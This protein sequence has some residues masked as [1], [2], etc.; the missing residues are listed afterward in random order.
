VYKGKDKGA[1]CDTNVPQEQ[2]F[3]VVGSDVVYCFRVTNIGD[4]HLGSIVLTD[5]ALTFR[6]SSI[7]RLRPGGTA[8]VSYQSIISANLVNTVVALGNPVSPDGEDLMGVDD[9]M[10][11]DPSEVVQNLANP[12]IEIVN[13]VYLGNDQGSSCDSDKPVDLVEGFR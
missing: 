12:S 7:G 1:Q 10:D 5:D 3:G 2:A 11:N 4:T 13:R 6:D 9:V 8:T